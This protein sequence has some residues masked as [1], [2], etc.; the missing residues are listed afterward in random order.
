MGADNATIAG[1]YYSEIVVMHDPFGNGGAPIATFTETNVITT[2]GFDIN[3][4]ISFTANSWSL[5]ASP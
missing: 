2:G 5:T 3:M 4:S 1:R